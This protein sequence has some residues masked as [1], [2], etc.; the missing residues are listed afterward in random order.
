MKRLESRKSRGLYFVGNGN[1]DSEIS[2]DSRILN[3]QD[4][5]AVP[6]KG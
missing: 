2:I 4:E 3:N 6:I 5:E 1:S